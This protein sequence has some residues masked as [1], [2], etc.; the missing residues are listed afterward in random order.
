MKAKEK[1]RIWKIELAIIILPKMKSLSHVWLFATP[2]TEAHQAPPSMEF[3]KQEYWSGLPF[4]SPGDF[5]DPG[6]E[7]RSP[8]SPTSQADSLPLS[9]WGS[10][11][12]VGME[13]KKGS[14]LSWNSQGLRLHPCN[15]TSPLEISSFF[16]NFSMFS[17][18]N[19]GRGIRGH[20]DKYLRTDSPRVFYWS[21]RQWLLYMYLKYINT[22]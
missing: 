15:S 20:F 5:P 14:D 11:T 12:L 16:K 4:P 3:S 17:M 1:Y 7:S 21:S 19:D 10:P 9:H 18:E 8:V 22:I 13:A 6:I 2:W